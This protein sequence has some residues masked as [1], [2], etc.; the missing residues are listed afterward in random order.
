MHNEK[1]LGTFMEKI[2]E[3]Q[4]RLAE[5]QNFVDDHLYYSHLKHAII[6]IG[7]K[8]GKA[9][10]NRRRVQRSRKDNETK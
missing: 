4:E 9:F 10:H 8:N 6:K 2:A 7:D 3:A 1:A 5:L